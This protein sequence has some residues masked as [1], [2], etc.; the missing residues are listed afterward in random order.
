MRAR[1]AAP[2]YPTAA[3]NAMSAAPKSS[4]AC[5]TGRNARNPNGSIANGT[6]STTAAIRTPPGFSATSAMSAGRAR[7]AGAVWINSSAM[8]ACTQRLL[9]ELSQRDGF[10]RCRWLGIG[11]LRWRRAVRRLWGRARRERAQVGRTLGQRLMFRRFL[12]IG[13]GRVGGIALIDR[14][15]AQ[16]HGLPGVVELGASIQCGKCRAELV[17][18]PREAA[19]FGQVLGDVDHLDLCDTMAFTR[20]GRHDGTRSTRHAAEYFGNAGEILYRFVPVFFFFGPFVDVTVI[21]FCRVLHRFAAVV[22]LPLQ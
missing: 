1:H 3:I 6:A 12:A 7:I 18:Q 17:E 15:A 16:F 11:L 10:L 22:G 2:A 14:V 8:P 9:Q 21:A 20:R 5:L 4:A 19:A 13:Q